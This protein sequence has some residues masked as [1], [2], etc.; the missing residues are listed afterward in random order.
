ME[1][2]GQPNQSS[3]RSWPGWVGSARA[4]GDRSRR[5]SGR[6]SE[7]PSASANVER[8]SSRVHERR[9]SMPKRWIGA[10]ITMR[11]SLGPTISKA[12]GASLLFS[13]KPRHENPHATAIVVAAPSSANTSTR[14]R[15]LL[16]R[17]T[18]TVYRMWPCVSLRCHPLAHTRGSRHRTGS[19]SLR[20]AG[21]SG[22]RTAVSARRRPVQHPCANASRNSRK[23]RMST[24]VSPLTSASAIEPHGAGWFSHPP[25]SSKKSRKSRMSASSSPL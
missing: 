5:W 4:S 13:S 21:S 15:M 11:S 22:T 25:K 17:R 12:A 8:M 9:R 2:K 24:M 6:V 10:S 18:R 3:S 23:S 19:T 16:A 7:P 14:I 1:R 20:S